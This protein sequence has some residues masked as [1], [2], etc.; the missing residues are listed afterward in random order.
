MVATLDSQHSI[1][2]VAGP[3]GAG[4]TTAA[5]FLLR[6]ALGVRE[7]VNADPIAAGLSAFAPE[8]VAIAAGRV[9][10]GRLDELARQR[11]SFGFETTL[12]SRSLRH[13]FGVAW[14]KDMPRGWSFFGWR[15]RSWLW[16]VWLGAWSW[17]ATQC[18]MTLCG[19]GT[20]LGF[21]ISSGCIGRSCRRG[22]STTTAILLIRD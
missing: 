21:A 18:P 16:L 1:V 7:Y 8:S 5:P 2:I 17:V 3:N 14:L 22:S 13:G 4:K 10:L 11:L 9:M 12:A 6:D 19:D 20:R 15:V